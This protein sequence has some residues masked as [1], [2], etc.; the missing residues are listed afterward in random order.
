[1]INI[2]QQLQSAIDGAPAGKLADAEALL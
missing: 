1:M 2:Q